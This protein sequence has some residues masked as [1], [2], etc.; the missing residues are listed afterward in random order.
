MG[1]HI[2]TTFPR[3]NFFSHTSLGDLFRSEKKFLSALQEYSS[4][5]NFTE[6]SENETIWVTYF[7]RGICFQ[8]IGEWDNARKDYLKALELSPGQPEVLNYLGYSL[9]ERKEKLSQALGMIEKAIERNPQSGYIVDSLAWGLFKLGRYEE[10]LLPMK[11][12]YELLPFDP[13]INDHMG[14]I[15]WNNGKRRSAKLY[16]KRSLS[17]NPEEEEVSKI[18]KK[19]KF[20][21]D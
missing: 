14:D 9:I 4:A 13:I 16:W 3:N 12:A 19:I 21:M 20:G 18:K 11:K 5:L 2:A 15:L 7:F 17:F 6:G 1:I 10:A 8:E